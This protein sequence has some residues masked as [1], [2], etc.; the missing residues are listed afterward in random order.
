MQYSSRMSKFYLAKTNRPMFAICAERKRFCLPMVIDRTYL[1]R[2][3]FVLVRVEDGVI[4]RDDFLDKS[5]YHTVLS[6]SKHRNEESVSFQVRRT[7]KR[8][9]LVANCINRS[10]PKLTP[11]ICGNS[12]DRVFCDGRRN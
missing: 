9:G 12:F 5:L 1:L 11:T 4:H 10:I 2:Y 6:E 3:Q 7:N 8:V